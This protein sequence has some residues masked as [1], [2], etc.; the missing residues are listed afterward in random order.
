M[1][2]IYYC[3]LFDMTEP[4]KGLCN[5]LFSLISAIIIAIK[6][7]KKMVIVDYFLVDF[8]KKETSPI[9]YIID[10]PEFN[11]FLQNKYNISIR[12]RIGIPK[13]ES[14]K[15]NLFVWTFHWINMLDRTMFDDIIQN[16][17]F[18]PYLNTLAKDFI[19]PKLEDSNKINVLHLRLEE[20][21]IQHWSK[22]NFMDKKR[23]QEVICAKYIELIDKYVNKDD[24]NI[25]LSYST[26]NKVI[27]YMRNQGYKCFFSEKQ[28]PGREVNAA[29]D[30]IIGTHC[31]NVFI[32]NFNLEN[33]NGSSLSYVLINRLQEKHVTK[34]LV[35]LDHILDEAKV[36]L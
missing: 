23:F 27:E 33:L 25:I 7:N 8:S 26:E 29:L 5:Q 34:V 30:L 1:S 31:N 28:F 17:P 18:V 16:I 13:H 6:N 19:Q 3:K 10:I 36:V 15:Q 12:D 35:D 9:S 24:I 22:E 11:I 4:S 20:D 21:G 2:S 32:G 14:I